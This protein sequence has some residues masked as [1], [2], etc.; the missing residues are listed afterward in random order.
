MSNT[1]T[2]AGFVG[3]GTTRNL[4]PT[5]TVAATAETI[6]TVNTDT[7]TTSAFVVV[8]TGGSVLGAQA[9]FNTN[10]NAAI[11]GRSGREYGLPSGQT[12]DQ[13]FSTS[14][15][16]HPFYVRVAGTGLAGHNASQTLIF[17]LYQGTS[18]TLGSDKKLG[19]TGAAFA[20]AQ[21]TLNVNFNFYIEATLV[22]DSVSQVLSGSYA[23]NIAGGTTSQF[24]A[25][26]VVSNVVTSVAASGLSFLA[27]VTLGNAA[28]STVTLSEFS[29]EKI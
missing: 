25:S 5:Q 4:F 21:S 28:S 15:D 18:T 29:V 2:V 7:G 8:P 16:G 10:A 1:N 14:W 12:N 22:W 17:N 19:T 3:S 13:F 9:P 11:T 26:T 6:L 20:I 23:A 24:T 27:T